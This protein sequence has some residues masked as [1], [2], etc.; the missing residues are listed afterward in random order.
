MEWPGKLRSTSSPSLLEQESSHPLASPR[1]R[2]TLQRL[3]EHAQR[4]HLRAARLQHLHQLQGAPPPPS[5]H[6]SE[7]Y[8][9]RGD[10][11]EQQYSS[12]VQHRAVTSSSTMSSSSTSPQ[13]PPTPESGASGAA[14]S[15]ASSPAQ[16]EGRGKLSLPLPRPTELDHH[17]LQHQLDQHHQLPARPLRILSPHVWQG[18]KGPA[19]PDR[20]AWDA[21]HNRHMVT[22][23]TRR[24][25]QIR[26]P[27]LTIP[28][29]SV[30][31]GWVPFSAGSP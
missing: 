12:V 3:R 10:V 13:L 15:A 9:C 2:H 29:L 16:R 19:W 26:M 24:G 14:R 4:E 22:V 17:Q 30:S 1:A 27:K 11:T 21:V 31:D 7:D 28:L 23:Q 8:G 18:E 5:R 25:R 6:V 20:P